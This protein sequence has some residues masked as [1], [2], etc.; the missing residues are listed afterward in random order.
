VHAGWAVFDLIMASLAAGEFVG[1]LIGG[2]EAIRY[3]DLVH[4]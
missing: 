1:E 3:V 4:F 2:L